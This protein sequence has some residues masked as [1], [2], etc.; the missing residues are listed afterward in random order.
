[1]PKK[2]SKTCKGCKNIKVLD[3]DTGRCMKVDGLFCKL[4]DPSQICDDYKKRR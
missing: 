3:K 4:D 2:K 1:M